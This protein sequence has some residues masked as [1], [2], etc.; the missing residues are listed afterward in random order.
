MM[1][2][3]IHNAGNQQDK[4]IRLSFRRRDPF[5]PKVLWSVFEKVM[6]T[7]ARYVALDTLS[8]HVNS[9]KMPVGIGKRTETSKGRPLYV[10]AH[11]K[12]SIVE[13]KA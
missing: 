2:I 5:S 1:D 9:V 4:P 6:Q 3:S 11:L 10:M 8:Y 12:R 7:D 13:M